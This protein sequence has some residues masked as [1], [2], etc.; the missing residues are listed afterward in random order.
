MAKEQIIYDVGAHKGE[1]TE[2]YLLKGFVVIAI[3]ANP[4]FCL[5]MEDRFKGF[6]KDG[7]LKILNNA[8]AASAGAID[9]FV[10]EDRSTWGTA[11]PEF[12]RRK[13]DRGAGRT[14]KIT[15]EARTLRD[16]ILEYG[17]PH[18]CKID[19]E[20]NDLDALRS[21]CG[22][23]ETPRFISIE[24][25]A[26]TWDRLIEEFLVLRELGY[27]RFKVVDESLV[28]F[29]TC[30]LPAREGEYCKREFKLGNSGLFG[31]ELPGYW[32]SFFEAIEAY[33]QIFRGYALNGESGMF[34]NSR[35]HISIFRAIAALQAR[36]ARL[37]GMHT[38]TNPTYI[39]PP[40]GWY[41][42]H[43]TK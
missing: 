3:E 6:L 7:K 17:V 1:D 13:K 4:E 21:I 39:L 38:Y 29:Q 11:N 24:A 34:Y 5:L 14:Q 30:P 31:E 27:S 23:K 9:F 10:N 37:G 8:I 20:G 18:Y 12:V 43:A 16:I 28:R 40:N 26:R 15:V 33:R 22:L 25:E 41:D 32:L 2:F 35:R 36:L 19:I 42:T